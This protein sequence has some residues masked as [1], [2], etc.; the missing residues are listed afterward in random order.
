[1]AN[2][3]VQAVQMCSMAVRSGSAFDQQTAQQNTEIRQQYQG[4]GRAMAGRDTISKQ[5]RRTGIRHGA[6]PGIAIVRRWM[7]VSVG[8][9]RVHHARDEGI[10][11]ALAHRTRVESAARSRWI[12]PGQTGSHAETF[13]R[14]QQAGEVPTV[15]P[16]PSAFAVFRGQRCR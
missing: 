13:R 15:F 6:R 7:A 2:Y 5:F 11:E 16:Q 4:R 14:S 10:K 9:M 12:R 8:S 1:M 3:R